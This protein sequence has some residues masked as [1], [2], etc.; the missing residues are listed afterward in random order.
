MTSQDTRLA[1][2]DQQATEVTRSGSRTVFSILLSQVWTSTLLPLAGPLLIGAFILLLAWVHAS[3]TGHRL[4]DYGDFI[5]HTSAHSTL[6]PI[7]FGLTIFLSYRSQARLLLSLGLGRWDYLRGYLLLALYRS[8]LATLVY[9]VTSLLEL[10]SRGYGRDWMVM[11]QQLDTW[12]FAFNQ[13]YTDAARA[14]SLIDYLANWFL[15][16]LGVQLVA[17]ALAACF[18]RWG[19]RVG[20]VLLLLALAGILSIAR[21]LFGTLM[22]DLGIGVLWDQFNYQYQSFNAW[23]YAQKSGGVV[24][25]NTAIVQHPSWGF[26]IN[27]YLSLILPICAAYLALTITWAKTSFR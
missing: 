9:G 15:V 26:V 10:A 1:S 27:Y 25:G 22:P 11:N 21:T 6:L 4:G 12:V 18:L 7:F 23:D 2:L 5:N 8:F 24:D 14:Y 13:T 20:T 17:M 3:L 19:S 16:L